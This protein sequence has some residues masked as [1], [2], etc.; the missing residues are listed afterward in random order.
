M[1]QLVIT[2]AL[3]KEREFFKYYD[4]IVGSLTFYAGCAGKQAHAELAERMKQHD[5]GI[6]K[7]LAS[8]G[9]GMTL[10]SGSAPA[11]GESPM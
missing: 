5:A 10:L 6:S 8:V 7:S 9:L 2:K 4:N 1:S 3:A 11:L